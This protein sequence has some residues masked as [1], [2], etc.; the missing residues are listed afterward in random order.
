MK[1]ELSE[2]HI[3]LVG[4]SYPD[5]GY[6]DQD[7]SSDWS[8]SKEEIETNGKKKQRNTKQSLKR[9]QKHKN[10]KKVVKSEIK[11]ESLKDMVNVCKVCGKD[12]N[13]V[14]SFLKHC[15]KCLQNPDKVLEEENETEDADDNKASHKR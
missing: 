2:E 8:P 10:T 7:Y 11:T 12:F 5:Q 4:A 9:K 6:P 14:N 13:L 3:E 1:I 15:E